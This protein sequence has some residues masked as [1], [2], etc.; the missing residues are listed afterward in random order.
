MN[1]DF[2]AGICVGIWIGALIVIA[3]LKLMGML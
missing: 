2:E 1:R 3:M